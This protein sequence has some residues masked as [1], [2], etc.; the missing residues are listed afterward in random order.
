MDF[1]AQGVNSQYGN[2]VRLYTFLMDIHGAT[3]GSLVMWSD[4]DWYG[5]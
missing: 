4:D 1:L 2:V 3:I 5:A